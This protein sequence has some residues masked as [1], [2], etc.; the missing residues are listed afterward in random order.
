MPTLGQGDLVAHVVGVQLFDFVESCCDNF[1]RVQLIT[2]DFTPEATFLVHVLDFRFTKVNPSGLVFNY[3][4]V[5]VEFSPVQLLLT[6]SFEY[7]SPEVLVSRSE[8]LGFPP[9]SSLLLLHNPP[10]D[11]VT[12]R[13]HSVITYGHVAASEFLDFLKRHQIERS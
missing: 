3:V 8:S 5:T 12:V 11:Y 1:R 9:G 13:S 2:A 7:L 4:Q 6:C 10:P